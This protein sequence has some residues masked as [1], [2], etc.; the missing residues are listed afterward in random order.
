MRSEAKSQGLEPVID[1]PVLKTTIEFPSSSGA[2]IRK[3]SKSFYT[4]SY[5]SYGN[6]LNLMAFCLSPLQKSCGYLLSSW[7]EGKAR[8]IPCE[9]PTGMNDGFLYT[10]CF[11]ETQP[12]KVFASIYGSVPQVHMC[13]GAREGQSQFAAGS[14]II[15]QS[16]SS[17][18]GTRVFQA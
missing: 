3:K 4:L 16:V 14:F 15:C 18:D 10:F 2:T 5:F 13:H 6:H 9:V 12:W 17:Q 11:N 7:K 1:T 8:N